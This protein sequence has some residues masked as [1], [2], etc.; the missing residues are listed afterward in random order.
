MRKICTIMAA[1]LISAT[2]VAAQKT[3]RV[4]TDNTG[5]IL[6]VNNNGRLYMV[7]LGDKL[8]NASDV[9]KFEWTMDTGSDAS[10]SQR[11]HEAYMCSGG[12]DF[13][14]PAL[15]VTHADGNKTTY[16][17]YKDSQVRA[18]NGGNETIVTLAD[19]KYDV[20]VRLHYIAYPKQNVFKVWS[21]ITNH[22]KKEISLWKYAST[23]LYFNSQKYFLT[24]YHGDWAREAQPAVQQL[25]YGKKIIDTKLGTRA[26]MHSQPF[27]ELGFDMPASENIGR[28]MLGTIA[29]TGNFRCTFEVDNVGGLRVIPGINPYASAYKLKP[30]KTFATPEFIF[31]LSNNGSG[32][33]SR[34][35]HDWARLYQLKDGTGD[36]M[37]LLNNWES[38]GFDFNQGS[39]ADVMKEAKKLGVDMFLLDDGWFANKYPRNNDKAGLGDWEPNHSKLPDGIKGL[40]NAADEAGVKFGIWIEPEMVNPKSELFEK[41][42]DWVIMQPGRDTYYYRNQLVLDLA[43]P[44][45][46]DY[47]FSVIDNILK[48]NPGVA[49]FKWDCNSPITNIHSPYLQENQENLYIEYV[50]GLYNVL[51]RIAKKYPEV[52]MM[53]CS[54]GGAR[55]DYEALKYFTEFWCSDNTDPFERIYIQWSMSK[56]FPVKAMAS[57]VTEW[58]KNTSMK[59]RLDVASMCKLGFD[60]DMASLS[61]DDYKLCQVAVANYKRLKPVILDGDMYRLVS[62]YECNHAA[63]SYVAKDRKSAVVFAYDLHPRYKEPVLNVRL[64]GL[65]PLQTYSIKELNLTEGQTGFS[66]SFTGDYLMKVGLKLFSASDGSSRVLELEGM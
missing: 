51:Q 33:A 28:M 42:P 18:V 20:E 2:A 27:F 45:V 38:T 21:E 26:A 39:L 40:T 47:V 50:R 10:V 60:I 62:P 14:E 61:P 44:K 7:Y 52:P 15:G 12:E 9:D 64:Q 1:L 65:D 17:Y 59:F 53:L 32:E 19:N 11:G 23:M 13:F 58:N 49:Y 48:E 6:Q 37:T 34:N 24:N 46:Q 63:V 25:T 43:N 35:L 57:H 54:G 36:R 22:E 41:H 8:I 55:C 66:G 30:G 4:C 16:L 29:W 5:L 3:I 56:F 31:T